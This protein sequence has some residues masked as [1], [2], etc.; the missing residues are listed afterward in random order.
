MWI[1]EANEPSSGGEHGARA[2]VVFGQ[3]HL[4]RIRVPLGEIQDVADRCSPE[5]IDRLIV[6]ADNGQIAPPIREKV[7]QR[8]LQSVRILVFVYQDPAVLLPCS[9]CNKR[10]IAQQL[11][12]AQNLI[13]KI[14]QATLVQDGAVGAQRCAKFTVLN[15]EQIHRIGIRDEVFLA[16]KIGSC[17]RGVSCLLRLSLKARRK[18]LD[19]VGPKRLVLGAREVASDVAEESRGVP[20]R[21]ES[22][23]SKIKEMLAKEQNDFG[24]PQHTQLAR[25]AEPM[26]IGA[27]EFVTPGVKGFDW[28]RGVTVGNETIDA[29]LHLLSGALRKR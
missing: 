18:L 28:G 16:F 17:L 21:Q 19:L 3:D 5:A 20:Q 6:I 9:C 4:A 11:I 10:V 23:E 15:G 1:I 13:A 29:P 12:G 25:E 7:N 2:A 14:E 27:K 24:A 8:T 22:L 26:C